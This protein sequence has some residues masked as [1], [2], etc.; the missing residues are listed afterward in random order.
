MAPFDLFFVLFLTFPVL[1]W[2]I[3]GASSEPATAFSSKLYEGFK[4]GFFF[5]FGYFLAG[6]WWV[7]NALL[8]DGDVF[9]W[10]APLA[11]ILI[12][13]ALGIFWG[14]AT[15]VARFFLVR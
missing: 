5:G 11:I 2:L 6:T 1:V 12:P 14:C 8:V 10:A 3:D 15:A 4:P 9:A 7:G 13:A